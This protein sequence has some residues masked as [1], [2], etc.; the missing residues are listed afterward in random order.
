MPISLRSTTL[1]ALSLTGLTACHQA[2]D[3]V[4][5]SL[6]NRPVTLLGE[7]RLAVSGGG[8]TGVMSPVPAGSE[9]HLVFGADSAYATYDNGT[10][11]EANT[12]HLRV[13]PT[14]PGGPNEQL[15][16]LKSTNSPTGQPYYRVYLVTLLTADKLS[17][18]TGGGCAL[19]AQYVRVNPTSPLPTKP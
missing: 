9:Y 19:N 18:T 3:E 6:L 5:P 8:I 15:L 16:L 17:F 14:Y 12:Y 7:W 4:A 13:Q 11:R 2:A 10:L 1:L